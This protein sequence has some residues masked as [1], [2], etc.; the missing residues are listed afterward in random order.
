MASSSSQ[1]LPKLTV[2]RGFDW[3]GRYT[4]SPFVNKLETRLRLAGVP[5]VAAPGSVRQAP[6]GK[7][8][9]VDLGN[10]ETMGDS[11]LI[12]RRLVG[13]GVLPDLNAGLSPA[14]KAQDLALRALMEDKIYF[15]GVRERWRDNYVT[16]RSTVMA[17]IPYPIQLIIGLLAYNKATG[18][19][20]GQG[21]GRLT[22]DQVAVFQQEAWEALNHL[23]S[24]ARL[25]APARSRDAPFWIL[26]GEQPTE[27]DATLMGFIVST[28]VCTAAPEAGKVV[29]GFPI[30]VDY[31]RRIHDRYF[32]DYEKWTE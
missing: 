22:Q 9:Y 16:M 30:L 26:G 15:Y 20:N 13:D 11:T 10:G 18:A 23:L 25:N 6:M 14:Q 3:P 32:S 28:L 12:T 4:W 17:A 21:T 29:R 1:A 19:L 2:Y 27:A 7:I 24:E 8:P 31:C 5:Y